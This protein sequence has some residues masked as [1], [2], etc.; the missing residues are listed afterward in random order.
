MT[1]DALVYPDLSLSWA[2]E[3][4][5]MGKSES[6]ENSAK[7]QSSE[8]RKRGSPGLCLTVLFKKY[9]GGKKVKL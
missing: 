5:D 3:A 4:T 1:P 8:N 9:S 2:L 7:C 6:S